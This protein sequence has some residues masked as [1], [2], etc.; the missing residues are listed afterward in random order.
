M[1]T[2]AF[3]VQVLLCDYC[4]YC[5]CFNCYYLPNLSVALGL[6][7]TVRITTAITIAME[8]LLFIT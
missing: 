5:S 2:L 4:I 8:Y 1:L 7:I 6:V 3:I